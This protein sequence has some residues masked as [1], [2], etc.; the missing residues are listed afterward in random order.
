MTG[1]LYSIE[2]GASVYPYI[3]KD[4]KAPVSARYFLAAPVLTLLLAGCSAVTSTTNTAADMART[5]GHGLSVSSR[6]STDASVTEPDTPRHA[7]TVAF[8]ESQRAPLRREAAAGG[9]EH[10]DALARLLGNA[11]NDHL[12]RWLQRNY[13]DVFVAGDDA[14]TLVTRIAARRG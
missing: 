11:D 2:R 10:I 8:V 5:A 13:S 3:S 6:Q 7:Q 12:G 4:K 1:L 14:E 9:G